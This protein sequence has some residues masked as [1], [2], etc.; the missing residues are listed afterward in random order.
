[1]TPNKEFFGYIMVKTMMASFEL[2]HHT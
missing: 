1:V 2:D